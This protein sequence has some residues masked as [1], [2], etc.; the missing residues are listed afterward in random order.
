MTVI[1]AGMH[2][3][4]TGCLLSSASYTHQHVGKRFVWG[5]VGKAFLK[6]R[7]S[8]QLFLRYI[9]MRKEM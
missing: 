1:S 6:E 2:G 4:P 3:S 5:V 9:K 7:I 8:D